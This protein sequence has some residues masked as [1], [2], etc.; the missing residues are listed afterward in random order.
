MS[1]ADGC[2]P[3]FFLATDDLAEEGEAWV[4]S[5]ATQVT[6]EVATEVATVDYVAGRV[7]NQ[8]VD[9]VAGRLGPGVSLQGEK[10]RSVRTLAT[11][12]AATFFPQIVQVSTGVLAS[13]NRQ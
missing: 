11:Q 2:C 4:R 7:A 3:K 12:V 6:T 10:E 5:Q 8:V 9:R 1:W 13:Q